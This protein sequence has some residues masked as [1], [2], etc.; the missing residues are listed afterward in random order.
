[1]HRGSDGDR[2]DQEYDD[3]VAWYV[4]LDTSVIHDDFAI[5]Q[6]D[7]VTLLGVAPD[8]DLQVCVPEV[9][10]LEMV[11]H[12]H[13]RLEQARRSH[14]DA[15]RV[16]SQALSRELPPPFTI[17]ELNRA[18]RSYESRLRR[19]LR[20]LDARILPLPQSRT[21]LRSLVQRGQQKRKPLKPDGQGLQD[22]M[23]WESVIETCRREPRPVALITANIRDF[24]HPARNELHRDLLDDL[25]RVDVTQSEI[26]VSIAEFNTARLGSTRRRTPTT[27]DVRP[28]DAETT[29]DV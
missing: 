14:H 27:L 26:Y 24:K 6:R 8:L 19:R 17:S 3:L 12:F 28:T 18:S 22:A 15:S 23:I 2:V 5:S 16:L 29:P 21:A 11:A 9:V 20:D 13:A 7:T 4:V 1:M 10:V 25:A